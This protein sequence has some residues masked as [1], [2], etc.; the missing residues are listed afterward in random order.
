MSDA[1][2]L[3]AY[4]LHPTARTRKEV[5]VEAAL[6][7]WRVHPCRHTAEQLPGGGIRKAKTPLLDHWNSEATDD[8]AEVEELWTRWPQALVGICTGAGVVMLDFDTDSSKGTDAATAQAQLEAKVGAALPATVT[9]TTARGG[10]HHYYTTP[11]AVATKQ[12]GCGVAGFDTRGEGGYVVIHGDTVPDVD[13]MA[14]L[15]AAYLAPAVG[16]R[17]NPAPAPAPIPTT[18]PPIV[19]DAETRRLITEHLST[20][21]PPPVGS[22]HEQVLKMARLI[23]GYVG[24][25][26]IDYTTAEAELDAACAEHSDVA[27]SQRTLRDGLRSGLASPIVSTTP[28]NPAASPAAAAAGVN[29]NRTT[30]TTQQGGVVVTPSYPTAVVDLLS[31]AEFATLRLDTFRDLVY[32]NGQEVADKDLRSLRIDLYRLTAL[33]HKPADAHDAALFVANLRGFDPVRDYVSALKWDGVK[34]IDSWLGRVFGIDLSPIERAYCSKFMVAMAARIL[35]PGCQADDCL[36]II[37]P[38][39]IR[40]ST[41]LR[42]LMPEPS[43]FTDTHMDLENKDT[44][45]KLKRVLL[46]EIGEER[47]F[48]KGGTEATKRFLS[49]REDFFRAPYDKAV[50]CHPRHCCFV[51]TTN[52]RKPAIFRDNTAEAR[53]FW[54]ISLYD[55][56][57]TQA[58]TSWLDANRDQLWAEAYAAA[59]VAVPHYFDTPAEKEAHSEHFRTFLDESPDDAQ[60]EV[61]LVKMGKDQFVTTD[62]MQAMFLPVTEYSKWAR[63]VNASL[64]RLG[65]E[66]TGHR[67]TRSNNRVNLWSNTKGVSYSR[68]ATATAPDPTP[69]GPAH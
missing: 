55:R 52:D 11:Q 51:V 20:L 39:G 10:F 62:V 45:M 69:T 17:Y 60:V 57:V 43:L 42:H 25:G 26:R 56:G 13:A 7:G 44:A 68:T 16:L 35:N 66:I 18:G 47:D 29:I 48:L 2:S 30:K 41:M 64:Q 67:L 24:A 14:E 38:P 31:H 54:P 46:V 8:P 58:D 9:L 4:A 34:R 63:R 6:A 22:R 53:R 36:S 49:Q 19:P 37:G 21:R 1:A 23:G 28:P 50:G 59:K 3:P 5:A 33:N 32:W 65:F 12:A 15:P 61:A 27:D 40:K